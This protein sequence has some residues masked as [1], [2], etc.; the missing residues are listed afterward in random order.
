MS[1]L[2]FMQKLN[3]KIRRAV[4]LND[5]SISYRVIAGITIPL[6]LL[7]IA[8]IWSWTASDRVFREVNSVN[9]ER[10]RLVLLAHRLEKNL[11]QM[12]YFITEIYTDSGK[13]KDVNPFST[14]E[15]FYNDF[16]IDLDEYERLNLNLNDQAVLHAV[17][18]IREK[19]KEFYSVGKKMAEAFIHGRMEEGHQAKEQ[20]NESSEFI[21]FYLEPLLRQ[22]RDTISVSMETLVSSMSKL[23]TGLVFVMLVA[24]V[25]SALVGWLLVRSLVPPILAMARQ[26][27]VVAEGDLDSTISVIGRDELSEMAK[28]FNHMIDNLTRSAIATMLQSGNVGAVVREQVRLNEVLDKNSLESMQLSKRV[29]SENDRLDAQVQQL[30]KSINQASD[31]I[32]SVSQ[33]IS[34]LLSKNIAP[35]VD[36]ANFTS[37]TVD[38]MAAAAKQ[39]SSNIGEIHNSLLMVENSVQSVGHEVTDLSNAIQQVRVRC[40]DASSRSNTAK[41]QTER[42]TEVMTSLINRAGKITDIVDIINEIAEQ[43]NMLALNAAIEAAGAGQ[44]GKGFA[45]VANEVKELARQTAKATLDIA[46]LAD[47]IRESVSGVTGATS[48][49]SLIIGKISRINDEIQISIDEQSHSIESIVTSMNRVGMATVDVKYNVEELLKASGEVAQSA[50]LAA[51]STKDIASDA[52]EASTAAIQVAES[53]RSASSQADSVRNFAGEI[54]RASAHVQKDMLVSMDLTN[55]VRA[56][57]EYSN[58]LTRCGQLASDALEAQGRSVRLSKTFWNIQEIKSSHLRIVERVRRAHR[59]NAAHS[60][61]PLPDIRSCS[62]PEVF[63]SGAS[64]ITRIH[65]DFHDLAIDCLKLASSLNVGDNEILKDLEQKIKTME[66]TMA[67]L[68]A[69]LDRNYVA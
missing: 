6:L 14:T 57:I 66:D 60:V 55:L 5:Y 40:Q 23:K 39:M 20:F 13:N 3:A 12:Q 35:I 25:T 7:L 50:S 21:A 10:L 43:T 4:N 64:E 49:L 16:I 31:N 41:S 33:S 47:S 24:I 67:D 62:I 30:Q 51:K 22:E 26:M 58:V 8:G 28:I 56:S 9:R 48:E 42:T 2:P 46:E 29:V 19:V 63:L 11:L 32:T 15:D 36:N 52:E 65:N 68:F 17:D 54:Y 69:A 61:E 44:A 38:H 18:Q 27:H 1:A 34:S 37:N 45:V 59:G 53:S